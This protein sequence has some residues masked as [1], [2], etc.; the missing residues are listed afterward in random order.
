MTDSR[1]RIVVICGPTAAG[2]TVVAIDLARRF[3]GEIVGA[4]S[5]Q[6]YRYM[7]IGTAKPTSEERAVVPHHLVDVVDPDEPF[8]AARYA[9]VAGEAVRRLHDRGVVPFVT[10]GTGLYIKALI[11]GIFDS[12]PVDPSIRESLRREAESLGPVALHERLS[13]L[14]PETGARLHVND[15]FRVV[16]ALEV[17]ETTGD[18]ISSHH[19]R[20]RFADS[21]YEVL[22]LGIT[23]ERT[24]LYERIDRRV[25]LMIQSGLL[26]EVRGLIDRGY[27]PEL[28]P[29]RSIGYRHMA[30]FLAGRMTWD[31][32]IRILQ[33][34]TRRYAKRQMTWF[35]ADDTIRWVPP[36][37]ME[38][39]IPAVKN[40]LKMN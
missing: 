14:D 11:R 25:D 30:E 20:H 1:T 6:I 7:D 10:G 31:E 26:D 5:M 36:D 29:M 40:F 22:S 18:S 38:G 23:L 9:A 15:V 21:P 4:D 35:G 32:A 37:Q 3:G 19:G 16:R 2:K 13:R 34:D 17:L 24:A 27:G 12:P 28:K 39:M 8:D 33:R